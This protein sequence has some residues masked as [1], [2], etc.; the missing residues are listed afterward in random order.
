MG[1]VATLPSIVAPGQLPPA[2]SNV[3][4]MHTAALHVFVLAKCGL[5]SLLT[6]EATDIIAIERPRCASWRTQKSYTVASAVC[7]E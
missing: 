7:T 3:L 4:H 6:R 2:R 1:N 5:V